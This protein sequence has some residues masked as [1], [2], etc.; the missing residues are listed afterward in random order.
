MSFTWTLIVTNFLSLFV[1][2]SLSHRSTFHMNPHVIHLNSYCHELSLALCHELSL[3]SLYI[4]HECTSHSLELLL[5]R[6]FSRS[7]S[8]TLSLIALHFTWMHISFTWTLHRSTFHMNVHLHILTFTCTADSA[9]HHMNVELYL[10]H[11]CTCHSIELFIALH[12]HECT[13]LH[14]QKCTSL[15]SHECRALSILCIHMDSSS[16]FM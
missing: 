8:R 3:S 1:T 16:L 15:Q 6:T 2:N 12:S 7:L 4:S 11:E 10:P 5:S 13:S 9:L 14:S